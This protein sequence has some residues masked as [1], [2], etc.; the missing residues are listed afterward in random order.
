M[1]DDRRRRPQPQARPRRHSRDRVLRPDP[2]AHCR[3]PQSRAARARHR[4]HA[5]GARRGRLDHARGARRTDRRLWRPARG[6][7]TA[8]RWSPTSRPTRFRRD[9][10][11]AGRGRPLRGLCRRGGL[12]ARRSSRRCKRVQRH[13]ASCSRAAPALSAAVG[14]LVF[15]G[16]DGRSGDA[17]DAGAPRL[18]APP[19]VT[20]M[21]RGWHFGRYP[22]MRSAQARRGS[23]GARHRRCSRRSAGW[24]AGPGARALRPFPGAHAVGRTSFSRIL[25]NNPRL[26]D[27]SRPDPRRS[28][29]ASPSFWRRGR[30]LSTR[31]L[32][33]PS[34][35]AAPRPWSDGACGA[36][37]RRTAMRTSSTGRASSA[38]SSF[39]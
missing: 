26:L 17:G 20:A 30:T 31:L 27:A 23:D 8:C 28:P 11:R 6:S 21:I 37:H 3:R 1:S 7:S 33:P 25:R 32:E 18:S 9:E 22:A 13:Y 12:L 29:R 15:T 39:P 38:R 5:G 19:Q 10:G 14:S 35:R 16:D 34:R 24:T 4:R 36:R 2:A